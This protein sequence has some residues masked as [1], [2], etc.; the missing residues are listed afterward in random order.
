VSSVMRQREGFRHGR[1]PLK[2]RAH[3]RA[4]AAPRPR[5]ELLRRDR[6]FDPRTAATRSAHA[7]AA[8]W[9]PSKAAGHR[10]S[11]RLP[12]SSEGTTGSKPPAVMAQTVEVAFTTRHTTNTS[13]LLNALARHFVAPYGLKRSLLIKPVRP[14]LRVLYTNQILIGVFFTGSPGARS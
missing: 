8:P 3:E 1:L 6:R 5:R 9:Q 14:A 11:P 12:Q 7:V 10:R 2:G 4:L 13:H